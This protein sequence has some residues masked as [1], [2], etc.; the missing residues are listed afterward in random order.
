[1]S[2]EKI[3]KPRTFRLD[4]ETVEKFKEI[5]ANTGGSQQETLAKLIE[6]YEIQINK[7]ILTEKKA[8]IEQFER[9]ISVLTRMYMGVLE[10]NQTIMETVRVE[11]EALLK[12]KDST[13][14]DLQGRVEKAESVKTDAFKKMKFYEEENTRLNAVI[15]SLKEEYNTKMAD[16]QTMLEDKEKLNEA[17][18]DSTKNLKLRIEDMKEEVEK[19]NQ[20]CKEL[21]QLKEKNAL[22]MSEKAELE[23]QMQKEC[24]RY[25]R[26]MDALEQSKQVL[27]EEIKGQAQLA[28]ERAIFEAEKKHQEQIEKLKMEKQEAIDLY[29]QKYLELLGQLKGSIAVEKNS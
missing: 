18:A 2:E 6:V 13:I 25:R 10:D 8:E 22:L 26:D 3:L 9:H 27:E 12:S 19:S 14:Q 17:L 4:E 23:E 15:A 7:G 21:E 16:M 29:Q 5:A 1:M 24:E 20:V 11:F 28:C